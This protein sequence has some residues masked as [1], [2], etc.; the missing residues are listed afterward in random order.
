MFNVELRGVVAIELLCCFGRII[1]A[2][3]FKHLTKGAVYTSIAEKVVSSLPMLSKEAITTVRRT[4]CLLMSFCLRFHAISSHRSLRRSR[5]TSTKLR[6]H[7]R[8]QIPSLG[9]I[10]KY[11]TA[12]ACNN[13]SFKHAFLILYENKTF[14]F[15]RTLQDLDSTHRMCKRMP[16]RRS[17]YAVQQSENDFRKLPEIRT[18]LN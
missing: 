16:W 8:L 9:R 13:L 18:R 12:K 4:F 5:T 2:P 10:R 7:G 17:H 11:T 3:K 6:I 1:E 14:L 15:R